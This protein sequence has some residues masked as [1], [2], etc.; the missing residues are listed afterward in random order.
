MATQK[1]EVY[2]C[3]V[4]GIVAEVCDGGAGEMICCGEPMKK[5]EAKTADSSTEK[6]VPI[7]EEVDEGTKVTVG[8]TLH[9]MEQQ[10]FIQWIELL[11]DG[12]T[13]KQYLKP[14]DEPV[15]VFP[16]KGADVS[17]REF[18]NVHGLWKA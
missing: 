2:K 1:L 9:P 11:V 3:M 5:M 16:V 14:G 15:A 12:K 17:A 10:H 13:F 18:C 4:C 8:S 7:I 6:H